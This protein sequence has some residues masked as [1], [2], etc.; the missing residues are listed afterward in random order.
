MSYTIPLE[1]DCDTLNYDLNK[2]PWPSWVLSLMQEVEPGITDLTAIHKVLPVDRLEPLLQ[3]V[4]MAFGRKEFMERFDEFIEEYM[5][6][7]NGNIKY[8]V[9]RY[10]TVNAVIP[11]QDSVGRK[12]AWH[13]DFM[14]GNGRG[15]RKVWMPLTPA[16]DTNTM[17]TTD[18]EQG[19]SLCRSMMKE[20]WTFD[21]FEKEASEISYPVNLNPGQACCFDMWVLHGNQNNKTGQTRVSLD[22]GMQLEGA[23]YRMR[24]PGGYYRLP[25]DHDQAVTRSRQ[26]PE[27]VIMFVG[28]TTEFDTHI[29][30]HLQ[31]LAIE[32]YLSKQSLPYNYCRNEMDFATWLP[33]L[34]K[35]LLKKPSIVAMFS[36]YSLPEDTARRNALL[37]L[38][39]SLGVEMQFVNESIVMQTREDLQRIQA[40]LDWPGTK[41]S[42]PYYWE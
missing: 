10:P 27:Q 16:F 32:R 21:R 23:E 26:T 4:Q 8:L 20:Q 11:D 18:Y 6:P 14:S 30:K 28:G 1:W 2:Y 34:E 40:Y 33:T 24:L 3:H 13:Q 12:V 31:R 41:K 38:A 29:P 19:L 22:F 5:A 42:G 37:E 25:G 35:S 39:L 17:W 9:Q 7:R 36:I 15:Q